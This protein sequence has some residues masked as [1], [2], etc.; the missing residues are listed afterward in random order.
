MTT[1]PLETLALERRGAVAIITL[2]RAAAMNAINLKM[3]RELRA[4]L[5]TLRRDDSVHAAILTGSGDKAFCAGMDLREFAQASANLSAAELRRLRWDEHEGIA[6]F[7][8]PIIAAVNGLAIGGGVELALLCDL[9]FASDTASFAFA[10]VKRGLM[11]GNGGTQRLARRIGTPRALDMILTGRSVG[12]AEALDIGLAQYVHPQSEVVDRAVALAD[13]M[14]A[15]APLAVR[16]AKTAVLRGADLPIEQGLRLEQD[17]A[18]YLYT[19][20]DA[21]EGPQAFLEKRPP[22]WRGR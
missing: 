2:N 22:N 12:A 20:E 5:D 6:T 13:Q 15:N 14:A 21:R 18:A 4:T 1:P 10:E 3:R 17:L 8:K 7:D 16:T 11:P 19:T 9:V